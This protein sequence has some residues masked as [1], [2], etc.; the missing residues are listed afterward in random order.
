MM[1]ALAFP[2][3]HTLSLLMVIGVMMHFQ[4]VCISG[5]DF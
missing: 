3:L 5:D 1:V 2:L 4:G